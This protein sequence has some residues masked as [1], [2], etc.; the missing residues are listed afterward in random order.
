[1]DYLKQYEV[2]VA[3]ARENPSVLPGENH[4]VVPRSIHRFMP[5]TIAV[6]APE[7][8]VFLSHQ[9]HLMA[10]YL[11]WKIW[12]GREQYGG[13]M[14]RAFQ[15]MCD[16]GKTQPTPIQLEDYAVA[17][18]AGNKIRG[19]GGWKGRPVRCLR[20]GVLFSSMTKAANSTN[21]S[22]FSIG[23]QADR[24]RNRMLLGK[25]ACLMPRSR[26][27]NEEDFQ[28]LLRIGGFTELSLKESINC[29]TP[30]FQRTWLYFLNKNLPTWLLNADRSKFKPVFIPAGK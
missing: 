28:E 9:E 25:I 12:E 13:N 8:L 10:H 5:S 24:A 17:R 1:M 20:T 15:Y 23:K 21:V 19:T 2:L 18:Q 30:T 6:N 29:K 16:I 27:I 22:A 3:N 4:H 26:W 7:N 14:G 11:L